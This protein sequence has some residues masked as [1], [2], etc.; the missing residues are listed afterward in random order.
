MVDCPR[1]DI[2]DLLPDL[3]HD[4]L[5]PA[6]RAR[7]EQHLV[8]CARCASELEL[9]RSLRATAF[10]TPQF[11][12]DRIARAVRASMAERGAE[13]VPDAAVVPIGEARRRLGAAS[14][15]S[16][17][18]EA[19]RAP[20]PG[21]G[22]GVPYGWRIAAAIALVA[23]GAGGYALTTSGSAPSRRPAEQVAVAASEPTR[24]GAVPAAPKHTRPRPAAPAPTA[25]MVAS[26]TAGAADSDADSETTVSGPLVPGD[27][28]NDLSESDM[29][30]LLQSVDD[31]E[32]MPD[33]EP[34]PLRLLSSV[35]EGAL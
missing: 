33:L 17:A 2:R 25:P 31:L 34:H 11:N 26:S 4:Q 35:V 21:V 27:P 18:R 16:G 10:A 3:V 6:E 22:V 28:L 30:S 32:A 7:V 1:E 13:G 19:H 5:E 23:A 9:L 24:S 20:R 8:G 14:S 15:A 29:Q 12:V